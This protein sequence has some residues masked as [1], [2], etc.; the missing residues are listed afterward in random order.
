MKGLKCES[1][2]LS[3][4]FDKWSYL[5]SLHVYDAFRAPVK[6]IDFRFLLEMFLKNLIEFGTIPFDMVKEFIWDFINTAEIPMS[7]IEFM[8]KLISVVGSSEKILET[9]EGSRS[10]VIDAFSCIICNGCITISECLRIAK[11]DLVQKKE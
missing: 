8:R 9:N 4:L 3:K 10:F 11:A 5:C 2:N 7:L 1:V 6:W